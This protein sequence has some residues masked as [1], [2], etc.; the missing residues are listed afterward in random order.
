GLPACDRGLNSSPT[1]HGK[2]LKLRS[3]GKSKVCRLEQSRAAA[4]VSESISGPCA[5]SISGGAERIVERWT[6]RG[7]QLCAISRN[8]HVVYQA[9]A[10]FAADVDS[11][12]IAERHIGSEFRRIAAHQIWPLVPI[13]AHAVPHTVS[14]IFVVG[15]VT[16]VR[17]HPSRS[18]IHC[19][20][21]QSRMRCRQHRALRTVHDIEDL[22][23]FV[24]R[25]APDECSRNYGPYFL[26]MI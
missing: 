7:E 20:A 11:R 3:Q 13:H 9:N 16:R 2:S 5:R 15:T 19:P 10:E 25:L 21:L 1:G 12:F 4:S 17:N 8:A 14:E 24:C 26:Y 22:L 23:L 18:R 6:L